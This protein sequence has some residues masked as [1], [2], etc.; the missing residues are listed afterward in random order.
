MREHGILRVLPSSMGWT[1]SGVRV[2]P[3]A[4]SL[5]AYVWPRGL[6][7]EYESWRGFCAR[8]SLLYG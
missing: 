1:V 8:G 4:A 6:Y 2:P 3:G 5:C 7:P